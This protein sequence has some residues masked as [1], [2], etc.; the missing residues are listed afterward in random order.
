MIESKKE[1]YTP[2]YDSE[3]V[4]ELAGQSVI[5]DKLF[6]PMIFHNLRITPDPKDCCWVIERETYL[7]CPDPL[8]EE[9]QNTRTI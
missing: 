5:L 3:V 1:T 6:G 9:M 2:K 7:P 8:I 4:I